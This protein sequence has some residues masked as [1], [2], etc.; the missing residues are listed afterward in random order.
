MDLLTQLDTSLDLLLK[1]MSSSIAYISRKAKH[2][3][4]PGSTIPL[5]ILGKTEA[6]QPDE[7]QEAIS[8]LVSDLVEKAQSIREIILHLPTPE[9]LGGD[10]ELNK[11]LQIMQVEMKSLNNEYRAA[12][13][14][15]KILNDEVRQL[16]RL[17]AEQQ[18][19]GR[20]WLVN[21][22]ESNSFLQ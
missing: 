5:T 6:I 2:T 9:S 17:I 14:E 4:L 10:Q 3:Q 16:V 12:V 18:R 8:E 11:D 1:I 19:E 22:L 13:Q 7:M 20:V 15:I 21:E